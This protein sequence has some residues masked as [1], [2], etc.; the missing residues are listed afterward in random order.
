MSKV[1]FWPIDDVSPYDLSNSSGE[2]LLI[3][4]RKN[5]KITIKVSIC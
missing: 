2:R 4:Y 5:T 1:S 3:F